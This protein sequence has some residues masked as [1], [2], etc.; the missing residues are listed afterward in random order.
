MSFNSAR[1][2]HALIKHYKE[3]PSGWRTAL[4]VALNGHLVAR[5]EPVTQ[6]DHDQ[7]LLIDILA[8]WREAAQDSYPTQ[9]PITLEG[10]RNWLLNKIL[11]VPD[12]ILFW[13]RGEQDGF[14]LGHV[15]LF[16]LDAAC[17]TM[18]LDN[19]LR[20]TP[21]IAPG[22]MEASVRTVMHWAT[23]HLGLSE[24]S[25]RVFADNDR[26]VRLYERCGFKMTRHIPLV[27]TEDGDTTSWVEQTTRP[28]LRS[29]RA[30]LEMQRRIGGAIL[31][32]T[33]LKLAA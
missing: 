20:G 14:R 25:L 7:H 1:R 13:I 4:P 6:C 27:K 26:A 19:V 17:E 10:T 31:R 30:F 3:E 18:E 12:R 29:D 32:H 23:D 9:F 21:R 11:E 2:I 8:R 28:D 5:L 15:G 24:L 22:L 33:P 16:H